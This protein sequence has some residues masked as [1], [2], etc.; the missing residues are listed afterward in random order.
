LVAAR[1]QRKSALERLATAFGLACLPNL[2]DAVEF[3]PD[4]WWWLIV[5]IAL[6]ALFLIALVLWLVAEIRVR[7]GTEDQ[8]I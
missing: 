2:L 8:A 6:S 3:Q 1:E 7:R 5:R 4:S